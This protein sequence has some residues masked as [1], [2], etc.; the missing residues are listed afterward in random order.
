MPVLISYS[1][2]NKGFA[3]KLAAQI[4]LKGA[5]VWIDSWEICPGDS[6][7]ES[8]QTALS[9]ASAVVA[10]LTK[11]SVESVWCRREVAASMAREASEKRVLLIPV[12]LEDCEIPLF[13]KDKA[14]A[15]FRSDFD[16][17][18]TSLMTAISRFGSHNAGRIST[19]SDE[20]L[21]DY[22]YDTDFRNNRLRLIFHLFQHSNSI[23]ISVYTEID[24]IFNPEASFRWVQFADKGYR[25]FGEL[26]LVE[27]IRE[28]TS[29]DEW[30]VVLTD[31]NAV[32][33]CWT[34][35]DK[36]SPKEC[37]VTFKC[38]RLGDD[39]GRNTAVRGHYEFEKIVDLMKSRIRPPRK[40]DLEEIMAIIRTK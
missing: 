14:Y 29:T 19:D 12:L 23:P 31:P 35:R 30:L 36:R 3:E 25:E 17:G 2:K 18:I 16:E 10:I 6:I 34:V 13:L 11:E 1:H 8:V 28:A 7:Y 38:R 37:S 26:C 9:R 32:V 20:F 40:E 21:N 5:H 24:L 39:I 27:W 4:F 22:S 33:H 15:D